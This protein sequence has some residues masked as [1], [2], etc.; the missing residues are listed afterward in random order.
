MAD[1]LN[2]W[3]TRTNPEQARLDHAAARLDI[4]DA[5]EC[6]LLELAVLAPD[7]DS[8]RQLEIYAHDAYRDAQ[9]IAEEH[10]LDR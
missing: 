7:D 10:D 3:A 1:R 8:A 5:R 4:H 9:A 2:R 6:Y